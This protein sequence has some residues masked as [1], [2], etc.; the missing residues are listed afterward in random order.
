MQFIWTT[1]LVG[2]KSVAVLC[3]LL[4]VLLSV[5][6][7]VWVWEMGGVGG[8]KRGVFICMCVIACVCILSFFFYFSY[9]RFHFKKKNHAATPVCYHFPTH[10]TLCFVALVLIFLTLYHSC[11]LEVGHKYIA[12]PQ[13]VAQILKYKMIVL[14]F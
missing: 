7:C 3:A 1:G 2:H 12:L 8:E 10:F 6:A 11:K 13:R 9:T 4:S 5:C 14:F